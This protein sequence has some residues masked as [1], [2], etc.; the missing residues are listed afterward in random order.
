MSEITPQ[1]SDLIGIVFALRI[2]AGSLVYRLS[3]LRTT[4]GTGLVYHYGF[5]GQQP[6]ILVEAG[7]GMSNSRRATESLAEIFKPKR[8]ISAGF[9]GALD[10]ALTRHTII[11]A[12][13]IIS[14]HPQDG[15]GREISSLTLLPSESSLL[16]VDHLV[17]TIAEKR[18][19]WETTGANLVDMESYCVADVCQQ[20]G[21]PFSS[22]RIVFDT[23]EE[24]LPP[25]IRRV[26]SG[27][28]NNAKL[29][30]SLVGTFLRRPSS[31]I[32]LYK[33]KERALIAADLLAQFLRLD[34]ANNH[35][36][37]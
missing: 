30:G 31:L 37:K 32:D 14:G 6:L 33:Y 1:N 36:S 27:K 10:P 5:L 3:Q 4:K 13:K 8:I 12:S 35:H 16:T 15:L 2:E 20:L 9:A 21:I 25:E 29:L 18:E 24:E 19:L 17:D 11:K 22:V 7:I 23:A 26:T 28:K 34:I